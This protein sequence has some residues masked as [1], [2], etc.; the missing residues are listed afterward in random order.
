MK[1]FLERQKLTVHIELDQQK[2]YFPG[3]HVLGKIVVVASKPTKLKG[4][5]L[6]WTGRVRT[7][8][9]S[10]KQD[11]NVLF[12]ETSQVSGHFGLLKASSHGHD[13][14]VALEANKRYEFPIDAVI[15]TDTS[16]P[17][18]TESDNSVGG[19]IQYTIQAYLDRPAP[20]FSA[21]KTQIH[22]PV[23]E[24]IN[25]ETPELQEPQF[26]RAYCTVPGPV[27]MDSDLLNH[28]VL[29]V[30]IPRKGYVRSQSIPITVEIK[31]VR[32]YKRPRG[33]SIALTRTCTIICKERAYEL[34]DGIVHNIK[35]DIDLATDL[36]SQTT[37]RSL[38]IPKIAS[39]TVGFNARLMLVDYK[40]VVKAQ[41]ED[42][43]VNEIPTDEVSL[44]CMK[45]EIPIVI[46]TIPIG[47]NLPPDV[48]DSK[49]VKGVEHVRQRRTES[50]RARGPMNIFR[51]NGSSNEPRVSVSER[52]SIAPSS[53]SSSLVPRVP[54]IQL[55][56]GSPFAFM[57]SEELMNNHSIIANGGLA[58]DEKS[59]IYHEERE[60]N[61]VELNYIH[62]NSPDKKHMNTA[63]DN[64]PHNEEENVTEDQEVAKDE[65]VVEYEEVAD[66]EET[67]GGAQDLISDDKET[68]ED[69]GATHY[70]SIFASSD[71][72][73]EGKPQL[74]DKPD[75][76]PT[77]P[78]I[79]S[80]AVKALTIGSNGFQQT[81]ED[82]F[83]KLDEISESEP[84]SDESSEQDLLSLAARRERRLERKAQIRY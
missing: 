32:P 58:S 14:S 80:A 81:R 72:E 68:N 61:K 38:L 66:D 54:S 8:L 15:P 16:L 51:S 77:S 35:A 82:V 67:A 57:E 37:S 19:M 56:L 5:R 73:E 59:K 40:I 31:H 83:S 22:V 70:F 24:R 3:D 33:I 63:Y 17:S 43:A 23:L 48:L 49:F 12:K 45:V 9:S 52:D 78:T 76:K 26:D 84:D 36:F 42:T 64:I 10:S 69:Q 62:D 25:I 47:S 79:S 55:S 1:R 46:G 11:D 50:I 28:A 60:S 13:G 74:A 2:Y 44:S 6:V 34:P 41:L 7:N 29:K 30:S 21:T 18:C 75:A 39:P 65:E 27:P 20:D 71:E 53:I 4:I